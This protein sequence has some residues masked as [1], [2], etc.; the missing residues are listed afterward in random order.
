[1]ST[2]EA[3]GSPPRFPEHTCRLD[4]AKLAPEA[5]GHDP[6]RHGT[7]MVSLWLMGAFPGCSIVPYVLA[8]MAGTGLGRLVWG[9]R[10]P[11]PAA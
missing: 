3:H 10:L 8:H 2:N 5:S 9:P 6:P 4:W 1:M 11:R 7:V